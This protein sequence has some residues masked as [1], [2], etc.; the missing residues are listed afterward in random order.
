MP[1]FF[2][3]KCNGNLVRANLNEDKDG[4]IC[5]NCGA[6]TI[7]EPADYPKLGLKAPSEKTS[8]S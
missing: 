5:P 1:E 8:P 6:T 2:C 4:L 7:L 3:Y